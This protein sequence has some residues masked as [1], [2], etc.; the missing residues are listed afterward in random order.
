MYYCSREC[1]KAHWKAGH[2][3]ECDKTAG[4]GVHI[5]PSKIAISLAG[6]GTG[7]WKGEA[8]KGIKFGEKFDIKI[9]ASETLAGSDQGGMLLYNKDKSLLLSVHRS[10][11]SD[12]QKLFDVIHAF[13][14]FAGR[15]AYFRAKV[16]EKGKL[17]VST[18]QVFVKKW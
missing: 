9:Q 16:E 11:C 8:P 12:F 15:K 6:G 14:P 1:Q 18:L 2:K 10:N 4:D 7:N 17:F 3:K 13:Q 5:T